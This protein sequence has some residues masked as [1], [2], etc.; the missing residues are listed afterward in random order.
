[1]YHVNVN[2]NSIVENVIQTK[3]KIIVN[4]DVSVKI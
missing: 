3:V 4:A 1:M 2:V